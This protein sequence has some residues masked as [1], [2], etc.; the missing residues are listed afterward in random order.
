MRYIKTF[1]HEVE[2]FV[3]CEIPDLEFPITKKLND[4][5]ITK[6]DNSNFFFFT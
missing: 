4:D 3:F 5:G 1:I 2:I 6:V